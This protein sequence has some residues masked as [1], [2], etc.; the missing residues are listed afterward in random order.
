MLEPVVPKVPAP[1]GGRDWLSVRG[2]GPAERLGYAAIGAILL[3]VAL[4][5][6]ALLVL[7]W[8]VGDLLFGGF[9]AVLGCLAAVLGYRM[10]VAAVTG[11]RM[12]WWSGQREYDQ[13]GAH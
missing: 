10:V 8:S 9:G 5:G 7:S 6:F 13:G 2:T 3:L 4:A 1:S 12:Y 11:R